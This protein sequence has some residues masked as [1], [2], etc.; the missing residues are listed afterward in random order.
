MCADQLGAGPYL[1]IVC[2]TLEDVENIVQQEPRRRSD[3]RRLARQDPQRLARATIAICTAWNR[4]LDNS[5]RL[6]ADSSPHRRICTARTSIRTRAG[7]CCRS[8]IDEFGNSWSAPVC[9]G[10]CGTQR[11]NCRRVHQPHRSVGSG[12]RS[13]TSGQHA[14]MF[15][16]PRK[17]PRRSARTCIPPQGAVSAGSRG[18]ALHASRGQA[19]RSD[20]TRVCRALACQDEA[21]QVVITAVIR[22]LLLVA[23]TLLRTGRSFS[24]AHHLEIANA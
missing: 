6:Q 10:W 16:T 1:R 24:P 4:F 14:T 23:W 3:R 5:A 11:G 9:F 20:H 2:A 18:Q 15:S 17:R 19:L 13:V 12:H 7:H 22:K 21:A 8:V